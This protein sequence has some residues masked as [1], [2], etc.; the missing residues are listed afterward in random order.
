MSA[1]FLETSRLI[2]RQWHE[3][4]YELYIRLNKD[5]EVMEF[6]P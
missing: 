1:M 3:S 5:K 4:D 2:L 6:F